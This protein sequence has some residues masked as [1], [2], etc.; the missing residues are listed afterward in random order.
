MDEP[1]E[2]GPAN[3][4]AWLVRVKGLVGPAR[5][6]L[7]GTVIRVGRD[8]GNDIVIET[9]TTSSRHSE[10]SWEHGGYWIYDLNSTNG[11]YV[12]SSRVD[13]APLEAG[14]RIRFG[15]SGPEFALEPVKPRPSSVEET[16]IL[17]SLEASSEE[18]AAEPQSDTAAA[19][20]ITAEDEKLLSD[21]VRRAREAR[22]TGSFDQTQTIMRAMLGVSKDRSDRK[23][24]LISRALM[25][26]LL[27]VAGLGYWRVRDVREN[28]TDLD[29]QIEQ[30]ETRLAGGDFDDSEVEELMGLLD[31]YQRQAGA[32]QSSL[33]FSW[34]ILGE[35]Q[36]LVQRDVL[37]VLR[38]FGAEA[39]SVPP[40][41]VE[42]VSH[43]IEQ[44]QTRDRAHVA[45]VLGE[46]QSDLRVMQRIFEEEK[47][48]G[49]LAYIAMVESAFLAGSR[50]S[51]GAAG[52]WQFRPLTAR[53]Y[54]LRVSE[55]AD[56]RYDLEKSTRA[57]SRY[58][59]K[60]ILDFGT[61]SSVMLA[62][63][64]YNVGP[65]KVRRAVRG[66]EDPI[67]QRNFW[68]LYRTRALPTETRE[69]V[70]KIFAAIL[71]GR[72]PERYGF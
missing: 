51:Q 48:P 28:K 49:D 35:E 63:A 50:S 70:P 4:H 53:A 13:R 67:K 57:A 14:S 58:I 45:R 22:R 47:L 37:T 9:P 62:L 26:A 33:L 54:G 16:V 69:Y 6:R 27:V 43:F 7:R 21:A 5:Y 11:T 40:E 60:L 3:E 18:E 17:S 8:P 66:V 10:I 71:I 20:S 30:I 32:L 44:F 72:N 36:L 34:G 39:Y 61:G 38:R 52:P 59:R 31:D 46:S 19:A 68:Y 1:A 29:R 23:W 56:D 24:R 64:A 25:V 42:R 41:F 65:G 15:T 2:N 55:E 12:N